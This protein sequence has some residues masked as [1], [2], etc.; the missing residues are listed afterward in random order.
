MIV[1][2]ITISLQGNRQNLK[3]PIFQGLEPSLI[4][5]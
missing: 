2:V 1:S 3:A 5:I 4:F